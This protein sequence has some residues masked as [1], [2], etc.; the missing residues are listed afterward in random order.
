[1]MVTFVSRCEKTANR[2]QVSQTQIKITQAHEMTLWLF[3][4]RFKNAGRQTMNRRN[5]EYRGQT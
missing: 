3:Y 2:F 5:I 1:M 4:N